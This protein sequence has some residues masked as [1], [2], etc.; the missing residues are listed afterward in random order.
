[1]AA[2]QRRVGEFRLVAVAV[3]NAVQVLC[4]FHVVSDVTVARVTGGND[5]RP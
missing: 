3:A 1:M 5:P 2:L 4:I